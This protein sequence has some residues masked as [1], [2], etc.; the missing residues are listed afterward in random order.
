MFLKC[1]LHSWW[2]GE[3]RFKFRS[4]TLRM[5]IRLEGRRQVQTPSGS[6]CWYKV[7]ASTPD[8]VFLAGS[9]LDRYLMSFL[10]FIFCL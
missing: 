10:N 2:E 4:I 9:Q 7:M 5:C 1:Q 3:F 6:C 8:Q